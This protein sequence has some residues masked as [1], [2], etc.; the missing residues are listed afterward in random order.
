MKMFAIS[1]KLHSHEDV[2]TWLE[3]HTQTEYC[4]INFAWPSDLMYVYLSQPKD[5]TMFAL[6]WS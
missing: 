1:N 2:L 6:R 4:K 3:T 5:Q